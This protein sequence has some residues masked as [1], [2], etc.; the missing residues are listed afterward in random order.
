[1]PNY[2]HEA[3]R[4]RQYQYD[5]GRTPITLSTVDQPGPLPF[6]GDCPEHGI[7]TA[8]EFDD[9]PAFDREGDTWRL[10]EKYDVSYCEACVSE[11]QNEAALFKADSV[12]EAIENRDAELGE[13]L[14]G[15][16]ELNWRHLKR[17]FTPDDPSSIE[18]IPV[19]GEER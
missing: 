16:I 3:S 8:F 1:M 17:A 12:E 6:R 7:H 9:Q 2:T 18:R 15:M 4:V 5:S 14:E 10:R 19:G 13:V 11:H